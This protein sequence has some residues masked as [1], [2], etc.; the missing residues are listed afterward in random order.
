MELTRQNSMASFLGLSG[1]A[2]E[3]LTDSVVPVELLFDLK[4]KLQEKGDIIETLQRDMRCGVLTSD[5]PVMKPSTTVTDSFCNCTLMSTS[6]LRGNVF[7]P[8][9]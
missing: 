7:I 8:E 9:A 2:T 5:I 6:I 4:G 3:E 1:M